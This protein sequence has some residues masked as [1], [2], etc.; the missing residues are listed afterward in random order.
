M[1]DPFVAAVAAVVDA[2]VP[3]IV[4]GA[5]VVSATVLLRTRSM[6][7]AL[8]ILLDLFLVV[9]LLRLSATASWQAILTAAAIVVIRKVVSLG[10]ARGRTAL[11]HPV[12][13]PAPR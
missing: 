6:T 4:A 7:T 5:L 13:P 2:I 9:G 10:L 1:I 12:A 3:L 8:G 11:A